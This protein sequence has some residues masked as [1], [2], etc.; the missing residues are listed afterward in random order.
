MHSKYFKPV[1]FQNKVMNL[2]AGELFKEL[3]PFVTEGQIRQVSW[4]QLA[5]LAS[6]GVVVMAVDIEA[7]AQVAADR[8]LGFDTEQSACICPWPSELAAQFLGCLDLS[9]ILLIVLL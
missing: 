2:T 9:Y 5:R 8:D 7:C 6:A 1:N 3:Q 4:A